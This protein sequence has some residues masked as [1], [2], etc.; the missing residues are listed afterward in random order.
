MFQGFPLQ[1]ESEESFEPVGFFN[2]NYLDQV[3]KR[4]DDKRQLKIIRLK[5]DEKFSTKKR[6][7]EQ[8]GIITANSVRS[9]KQPVSGNSIIP[10]DGSNFVTSHGGNRY[11]LDDGNQPNIN[12]RALKILR[13]KKY[14]PRY[15]DSMMPK[16]NPIYLRHFNA[17]KRALKIIRLKKNEKSGN[18]NTSKYLNFHNPSKQFWNRFGR[19]NEGFGRTVRD[20]PSLGAH[21]DLEAPQGP[22]GEAI[23]LY[24][25]FY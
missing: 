3:T 5:K 15:N 2:V 24:S 6:S 16:Q 25:R 1:Y 13:L 9:E 18:S 10:S 20:L 11:Q 14:D 22:L 23:N 7:N 8:S 17:D 12:K 21:D 4:N 19:S